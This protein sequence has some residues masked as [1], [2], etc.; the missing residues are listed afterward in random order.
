MT[1]KL[2]ANKPIGTILQHFTN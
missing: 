2:L 1:L